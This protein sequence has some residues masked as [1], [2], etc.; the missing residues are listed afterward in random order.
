[1]NINRRTFLSSSL[2]LSLYAL[3]PKQL[4]ANQNNNSSFELSKKQFAILNKVQNHLYPKGEDNPSIDEINAT[5]YMQKVL[6][7]NQFDK[8][9]RLI[10]LNGIDKI[11][12]QSIAKYHKSISNLKD[13]NMGILLE[14]AREE[15]AEPFLAMVL[16]FIFEALFSDPIYGSNTNQVGWNWINHQQ[17]QPQPN[18]KNLYKPLAPK[19]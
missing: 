10:I 14:E 3:K 19:K 12:R 7:D 13:E 9:I 4:H 18:N 6:H 5:D 17:G 11:E 8:D 1:M 16:L 15:W 2:L